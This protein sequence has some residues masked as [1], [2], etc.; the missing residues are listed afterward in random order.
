MLLERPCRAS[1]MFSK[2]YKI[3][4]QIKKR[5]TP[6]VHL[7]PKDIAE[8]K[9]WD[10]VHVDLIGTYSKSIRQHNPGGAIIRK[11]V[12]MT[13]M[14]IIDPATGWFDIVEIPMFNI[15]EVRV[16]NDEYI[17]KSSVRVI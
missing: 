15:D 1:G 3:R 11:N 9:P 10:L 13:C 16:A 2:T 8:L 12:K 17:Y 5:K 7:P 4:Q 14:K 6:Y